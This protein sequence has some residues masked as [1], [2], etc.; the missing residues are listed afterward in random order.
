MPRE[1]KTAAEI[2]AEIAMLA[3]DIQEVRDDGISLKGPAPTP[4]VTPDENGCNWTVLSLGATHG[5]SGAIVRA[6]AS[7]KAKWNLAQ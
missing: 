4:L 6:I 5:H 3:N 2:T 7:V 1:S